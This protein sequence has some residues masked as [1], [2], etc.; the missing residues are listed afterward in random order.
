MPNLH[1]NIK[2]KRKKLEKEKGK[3]SAPPTT[4]TTDK[5]GLVIEMNELAVDA[6]YK[7]DQPLVIISKLG[8]LWKKIRA[9]FKEFWEY[10]DSPHP[11]SNRPDVAHGTCHRPSL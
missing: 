6:N 10:H 7:V 9:E 4:K 3:K 1:Q 2:R 5:N 11:N 8:P